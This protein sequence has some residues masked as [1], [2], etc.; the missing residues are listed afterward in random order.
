MF[1]LFFSK[2][3]PGTGDGLAFPRPHPDQ[4]GFKLGEGGQ[5]VEEHFAHRIGRI[6]T[7]CAEGKF[8]ALLFNLLRYG[9]MQG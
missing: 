9:G 7:R 8:D 4:I 3:F 2:F 1:R 5:N 6:V